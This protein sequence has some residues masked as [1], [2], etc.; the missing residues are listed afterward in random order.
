[1]ARKKKTPDYYYDRSEIVSKHCQY[2]VIFGERSNGKSYQI[3]DLIVQNYVKTGKQGGIIRR[4]RE[5]IQGYNA[6]TTFDGLVQNGLGENKIAEYTGGKWTA[7]TFQMGAWYLS[8]PDMNKPG[9][10]ITDEKPM[11]YAFALSSMEHYKSTSYPNIT[12]VLFDEMLTRMGYL[13]NEFVL[14]MNMLSTIIRDRNDVT[15]F[16]V[17]NTVNK[18]CIYFHE[19]GLS[20][21]EEQQPGTIEI[22]TYGKSPLRVAVE[23]T[24]SNN[25][26]KHK[27]PS[28]MYFAFNNPS[29]EMITGSGTIWE[30]QLYPHCPVHYSQYDIRFTYFVVYND[31]ILQCEIVQK[32]D[33]DNR[34][35]FTFVHPKTT[36][37]KDTS[38]DLIFDNHNNAM[39]NYSHKLNQGKHKA[40][41]VEKILSYFNNDLV[42]YSDNETGE[43]MRNY[44][45]WCRRDNLYK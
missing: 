9:K 8:T 2:N 14:F 3:E 35:D 21:T 19:M 17:G 30:L 40:G 10:M 22:Y 4:Q 6:R 28:D 39:V 42:F 24:G 18:D 16:M 41:V 29:L 32:I 23:F 11:C 27:K 20:H 7:V 15:I 25:G 13:N 33:G 34:Y 45:L 43:I 26:K 38:H 36:D 5:D 1:M 31:K 37:L 12:T 44:I